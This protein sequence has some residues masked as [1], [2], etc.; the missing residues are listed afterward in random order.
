MNQG[1]SK[2]NNIYTTW[3]CS[4]AST[5]NAASENECGIRTIKFQIQSWSDRSPNEET[6]LKMAARPNGSE[7]SGLEFHRQSTVEPKL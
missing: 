3:H 1:L 7:L 2:A 5:A 6:V 4:E